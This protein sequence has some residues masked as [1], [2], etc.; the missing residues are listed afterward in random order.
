MNCIK[1]NTTLPEGKLFCPNCGQLNESAATNKPLSSSVSTISSFRDNEFIMAL[2]AKS[3]SLALIG[4]VL[5]ILSFFL[6]FLVWPPSINA[7]GRVIDPGFNVSGRQILLNNAISA[8]RLLQAGEISLVLAALVFAFII[9]G[10]CFLLLS[11]AVVFLSL[12]KRS[13]TALASLV[14]GIC[15]L[16]FLIRYFLQDNY[17]M[18]PRVATLGGGF[19]LLIVGVICLLLAGS[20]TLFSEDKN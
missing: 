3:N 5:V 10:T 18:G 14:A 7:I 4:G 1:C 6:T 20:K 2:A 9:V 19:Y 15:G 16:V 17:F 11:L 8:F 12:R 13:K